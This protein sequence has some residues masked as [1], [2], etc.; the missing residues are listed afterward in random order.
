MRNLM[1]VLYIDGN[2][3]ACE[4]LELLML[5]QGVMVTSRHSAT[6][7]LDVAR[8]ISFS[9]IVSE[10]ILSDIDALELCLE[11]K[12]ISPKTPIV[13]FS[14][15]SRAEHKERGLSAGASAF[16]VKPNDLEFIEQTILELAA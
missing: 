12:K 3:D 4:I 6:E 8:T 11:L 5:R 14:T 7:A 16:L 1:Q 10:Y 9:A 13:F 15:E 2:T